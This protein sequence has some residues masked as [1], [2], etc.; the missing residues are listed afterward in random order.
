MKRPS[1]PARA[2]VLCALLAAGS[3]A[4]ESWLVRADTIHTGVGAPVQ[5]GVLVVA[6][7]KIKAVGPGS[8]RGDEV[9]ECAAVT[10]GLIDL[11]AHIDSGE[12]SVEQS[13]ETPVALDV[14]DAWNPWSYRFGR[15][16]EGGVTSVLLN[17]PAQAVLGG[18]SA[19]VKT[20]GELG[21]RV[22]KRRAVLRGAMGGAP[23]QGNIPPRGSPPRTF[24]FRRPTTRM[25]VE[26][27]LRKAF[28][29]ARAQSGGSLAAGERDVLRSVLGGEL[30]LSLEAWTTQ[31][32]RT[33]VYLKEEFAIPNAFV[34]AAAEAWKEPALL[35]RS[36]M[37]VVLP[38]WTFDGRTNESAFYALDTAARLHALGVPV[39][40]SG[41]GGENVDYRLARQPG[42]A[43]RGGLPFDAA[44]ASVTT[45]PAR[46][47]GVDDRI[48]SLEVG[49]DADLV[50]WS[51]TP[52]EPT[53]RILAVFVNGRLVVDH[54]QTN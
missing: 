37:G 16:L 44:L 43:M 19:V 10:P 8:G 41:H 22:V 49:K 33:A 51:G 20:G 7:G 21:E 17:P 54:R 38:P 34:D 4:Q 1:T 6:G 31:D 11:S 13:T 12:Y 36:K 2:G 52:F 42:F 18:L 46:L 15:E 40:L 47:A 14:L 28:L 3:T 29:D 53:S 9:I 39:A 25:G 32:I 30:P 27:L 5:G 35:V 48:G 45:V 23:S 26:W 24:Y 50:L